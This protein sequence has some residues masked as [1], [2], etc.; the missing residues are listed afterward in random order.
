MVTGAPIQQVILSSGSLYLSP[1]QPEQ[2]GR[3]L[4]ESLRDLVKTS[5][6]QDLGSAPVES[7]LSGLHQM[8]FNT[9]WLQMTPELEGWSQRTGNV[10]RI[11]I[12]DVEYEV[13]FL[14]M[15]TSTRLI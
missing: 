5:T 1:P 13:R 9:M 11:I 7:L 2:R 8:N 4:I 3:V 14:D 10:K 6:N 12:G 15:I